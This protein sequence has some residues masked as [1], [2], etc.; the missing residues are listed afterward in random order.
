MTL[1]PAVGRSEH[2]ADRD[3]EEELVPGVVVERGA[4]ERVSVQE[5]RVEVQRAG[6]VLALLS[7]DWGL[8]RRW[9]LA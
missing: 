4:G 8:R 6:Q 5:G 1:S 3:V 2:E 9:G 7:A